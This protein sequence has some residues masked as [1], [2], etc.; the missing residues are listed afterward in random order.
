MGMRI[1]AVALTA[2]IGLTGCCFDLQPAGSFIEDVQ[3][4]TQKLCGIV[5]TA[6]SISTLAAVL[7]PGAAPI[8]AGLTT[9]EEICSALD[10][11]KQTEGDVQTVAGGGGIKFNVKGVQIE[12]YEIK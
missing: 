10:T 7:F 3:Q 1:A 6:K 8:S 2:S 12:A 4:S 5:P 9:A 11:V